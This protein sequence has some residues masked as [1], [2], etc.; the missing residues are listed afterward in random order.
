[1]LRSSPSLRRFFAAHFQSQLGSG[2]AY[3]ALILISYQRLRSPWAIA[4]V[5]LADFL[6]G[7]LLAAPFGA[8]ADRHPRVHLAVLADLLRAGAFIALAFVPSIGATV[9][10]ALAAGVGTA[11]FRPAARAALPGLVS[12]EQRSPATALYGGMTS[13]GM[14]VGPALT[15]LLLLF[16]SPAQVLA[17]NGVTFV[18]SAALLR[19]LP[20]G[21]G[22]RADGDSESLWS[23]T[24]AGARAATE[25]PGMGPL[26]VIGAMS[27]LA[28][29]L[30]NVAEPLLATGPLAAG[31]SGYALLVSVY[32]AGMVAGSLANSRLDSDVLTLR[33]RLLLGVALSGAGMV[34][35]AAAPSLEWAIATFALTGLANALIIGPET[36]LF[37]ELVSDGMLGRLFGL[38]GMLANTAYVVAFLAS[39]ALI[40]TLGVRS[41]F[42]LGGSALLAL[43]IAGSIVFQPTTR[44]GRLSVPRMSD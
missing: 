4:L 22:S 44:E 20:L 32:G 29:A 42:A 15:A 1:M 13:F 38:Q 12:D 40:A 17:A 37:Q 3:V 6:P 43:A 24:R 18:V 27:V 9:V 21:H 25:I 8:L 7:I 11:L 10:L 31:K 41:L 28:G 35:S 23:A 2:A 39:G 30:M 34:G 26:L 14:T 33:R 36:R 5:L 16:V 19:G